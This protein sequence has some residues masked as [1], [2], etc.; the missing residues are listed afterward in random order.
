MSPQGTPREPPENPRQKIQKVHEVSTWFLI[1]F[2]SSLGSKIVPFGTFL[3]A[4]YV[5]QCIWGSSI[6]DRLVGVRRRGGRFTPTELKIQGG[7]YIG[8]LRL[9]NPRW[10]SNHCESHVKI[11][12]IGHVSDFP[13][14][15]LSLSLS[16][17]PSLN[18]YL[19][20]RGQGWWKSISVGI[21]VLVWS[22]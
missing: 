13:P 19:V 22:H 4:I 14:L 20:S 21:L 18:L 8:I 16:L 2:L 12:K 15:S 1:A 6:I 17:P 5:Q 9:E 3:A 10:H 11:R 7:F